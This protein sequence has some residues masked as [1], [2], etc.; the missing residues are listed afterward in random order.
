MGLYLAAALWAQD[1]G[2]PL[3]L[4][5]DGFAPPLPYRWV[6]PPARLAAENQPPEAGAGSIAL[7]AGSRSES[8]YASIGTGDGQAFV[9]FPPDA[10]APSNNEAAA[11]VTLTPLD[12]STIGPPPEGTRIDGNA[13][14]IAAT[15][16]ASRR[17]AVLRRPVTVVLR[18]PTVG[19]GVL[20]FA[21]SGWIPLRTTNVHMALQDIAETDRL[22]I[23]AAAAPVGGPF[24][25]LPGLPGGMAALSAALGLILVIFILLRRRGASRRPAGVS[26][27][28]GP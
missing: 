22:G 27:S 5:Y 4:L 9:I 14:R 19:T 12:P 20:R 24:A 28:S 2:V 7:R 18:Y 25:V 16:V 17:P 15:Y 13:Y 21:V 23:F 8:E 1:E 26:S 6:R 11:R 3:R 10:V